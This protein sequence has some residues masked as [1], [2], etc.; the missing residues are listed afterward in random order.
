MSTL[1]NRRF[2]TRKCVVLILVCALAMPAYAQ[3]DASPLPQAASIA[4]VTFLARTRVRV[5][6][7]WQWRELESLNPVFLERSD[8]SALLLVDDAQLERLA[9]MRFSP[10]RTDALTSLAAADAA[11][12][13]RLQPLLVQEASAARL[14]AAAIRA[15]TEAN[16]ADIVLASARQSL[17]AAMQTLTA[18]QMSVL[19]TATS[20]DGDLDGLTNTQESWWCTNPANP[21]SNPISSLNDGRK[22]QQARDWVGNL[23]AGRPEAAPFAGWPMLPANLN[24]QDVDQDGV[25]DFAEKF[26]LGLNPLKEST[27]G[28]KFD[29]GQKL[30]G[31]T[32]SNWG[33]LPRSEDLA[34]IGYS[35]PSWVKAPGNHPLVAAYPLPQ[36]DIVP[37]SFVVKAV[38]TIQTERTVSENEERTY[39][40]A[41][42]EGTSTSVADTVTWNEWEEVSRS[43]QQPLQFRSFS[44]DSFDST[45]IDGWKLAGGALKVAAG[46]GAIAATCGGGAFGTLVSLGLA[47]GPA[48]LAC[49]AGISAGVP[50]AIDGFGAIG[51]G[52]KPDQVQQQVQPNNISVV[53]QQQLQLTNQ[54]DVV[55]NQTFDTSQVVNAIQGTQYTYAQTGQLVAKRL[56]GIEQ[57]VLAPRVTDTSSRGKSWGGAKTTTHEQYEQ[58]TVTNGQAFGTTQ[59]WSNA[60]AI[61]SG[62]AADF[63]FSYRIS[64]GGTDYLTSLCNLAFNIYIGDDPNPAST[65]F[66]ANDIGGDGCFRNLEPGASRT[67]SARTQT[68]AIPLSLDELRQID[69]GAPVR[70]VVADYS[71]GSDQN[72]YSNARNANVLVAIEDGTDDGDENIDTYLIPTWGEGDTMQN[73]IGRYFPSQQ[74]AQGNYVAIWTPEMRSDTPAWCISPRRYSPTSNQLWC[75]HALST[76]DWWN[77]YLNNLGDGTG[78]LNQTLAAPNSTAFFRFNKDT[79]LDGYSDRTERKLGTDPTDAA[80][81]PKPELIAGIH[82]Q[83]AVG[84]VVTATASLL[85]TGFYDAYGVELVMVAPDDSITILNNTVGGSGRVRAQRSVI[86]GS[87]IKLPDPLPGQWGQTNHAKPT[88]GGYYTGNSD[89]TYSFTASCANPGGCDVGSGALTLNWSDGLGGSGALNFGS[90]YASPTPINV[91]A[92]G[93]QLSLSSG[94]V[95]NGDTFTIAARAPQDTFSYR[96][97]RTPYTE[98]LV[99]VSYNDP[100]GN[101]RIAVPPA[102]M[103]LTAPTDNLRQFS[104]DMLPDPGV[105]LVTSAPFAPGMNTVNL[106]VHN[107]SDKTLVNAN[108]FLEFINISGTVVLEVPVMTTLPPGPKANLVSFDT[109]SFNPPYNAAEDYVVMA[110]LTDYQGNILDTAG[111]PLSSFQADPLPSLAA[112]DAALTWNFGAVKQGTLLKR[113]LALANTGF[114][115]LY[116]YVP[117]ASGLSLSKVGAGV[118]SAA[119]VSNYELTL[120]TSDVPLGPYDQT[121]TIATSDPTQPA[122]SLR[123]FGT[124]VAGAPDSAGGLARPLDVSASF[125]AGLLGT[126]QTF[127]HTLGPDPASLHPVKV[128]NSAYASPP[129]GVGRYATDFGAGTSSA[130]MFGDGRD[131]P[132]P[133]G[134]NLD[135]GTGLAWGIVNSGSAGSTSIAVADAANVSRINPGDVVLIHQTQGAGAGQWELNKS[136]TYWNGSGFTLQKPLQYTYS[137]TGSNRAQIMRVPQYST[138]DNL[139][140]G[141]VLRYH[142]NGSFGGIFIA[143]CNSAMNLNSAIQVNGSAGSTATSGNPPG[144]VGGGF[145]G[146]QGDAVNSDNHGCGYQGEG[147]AGFGWY[148]PEPNGNGGGA[149][150]GSPSTG[151]GGSGGGGGHATAGNNSTSGGIGSGGLAAGNAELTSM[152]FGG[153]GGGSNENPGYSIGGGGSGGGIV[154]LIAPTITINANG[155]ISANGGNGGGSYRGAG[156]GAGGS[157][158]L[159]ALNVNVNTN[160]ITAW[161]GQPGPGGGTGS[162]GRIRIEYCETGSGITSPN[163]SFQRINCYIADQV[164][165]NPQ[166]GQLNVPSNTAQTYQ[167]QYGRRLNFG[168]AGNQLTALRM[169]PGLLSSVT[170]Q[171]LVS[172]LSSNTAFSL[173]VGDDG[174]TDWSG[175]VGNVSTNTS[176]DLSAAFNAYWAANGASSVNPLDVPVRVSLGGAGQVLLT[177]LQTQSASSSLR[178]V[179]LNAR[180]YTRFLLDFTAGSTGSVLASLDIGDDGSVDWSAAAPVA[181][182]ARWTTGDLKNALNSYLSGRSGEVEVPIRFYVT[183]SGSA[184][185]NDYTASYASPVDLTPTSI[186]VNPPVGLAQVNAADANASVNDTRTVQA[187]LQNNG[188]A[189]S[190]PFTAAFFAYAEGWGDWYVGSVFVPNLPAGGSTSVSVPWNTSGFGGVVPVKV[191]VNPYGRVGETSMSNNSRSTTATVN[192]AKVDQT[193][194]FNDIPAKYYTE[195]PFTINAT[196]SSGLPVTFSSQTPG[197]C[198]V[199]S[200]APA[201]VT[202]IMTGTCTIRATQ[203]GDAFYNAVTLDRSFTVND[204]SKLDQTITF[205]ALPNRTFGDAPFTVTASA[206]SGLPVTIASQTPTVCTIEGNT[207]TLLS[208]GTCTLRATCLGDATYNEAPFVERSFVVLKASQTISFGALA[209]KVVGDAP[210]AVSASA[211]SGLPV[212]LRSLTPGVCNLSGNMVTLVGAGTCSI[213]ASQ[214]G[215]GNYLA[216]TP[217]MQ[218]FTVTDSPVTPT[219]PAPAPTP[220][221]TGKFVYLPLVRR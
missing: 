134:G 13:A 202:L 90:G 106:L 77:I 122:R 147:T 152:V 209:N 43:I 128:F 189:D 111:R 58:H 214:P 109:R 137:S 176:P 89:R 8:D 188:S 113:P 183:P 215:D 217:V 168:G 84:N 166:Q 80:S 95:Y 200:A 60:T 204:P 140:S 20:A 161:A 30:W 172:G 10:E 146:G 78:Q 151:N 220:P 103:R 46:V 83:P 71:F 38:T 4:S 88:A 184:K 81:Y 105:E 120:R 141:Y 33:G 5:Q 145:R 99:I 150:C 51:E 11:L 53:Q 210:F 163:A 123:V 159:R 156:G 57:A 136:A 7:P 42:T 195:P 66:V 70:V 85:N 144:G 153:G 124:I 192:A 171:A 187:T 119:D 198:T 31:I 47:A 54:V 131:G 101:H 64:N 121:I 130:D 127:N 45:D 160:K 48:G 186:A 221:P 65:Y 86:V 218:S 155:S 82:Q 56:Y 41:K 26:E 12:A 67:F 23:R 22:V 94:K 165:G 132:M 196:A 1:M 49:L 126:W 190:G 69:L 143:M 19:A 79:D 72:F 110:F 206:S 203:A 75:K 179:R 178:Y 25:P 40:T 3:P 76:A 63:W 36:I 50:T 157:V 17:R 191:V 208:T 21:N 162:D 118:V 96:I 2:S 35:M 6:T 133:T 102:A 59:G 173:D 181:A 205:A 175:T 185:I 87:S 74:D 193:I 62:H 169:P 68:R 104:G 180:T 194:A 164:A 44:T 115:Q 219:P 108:L 117:P 182:P 138:C 39:S 97:N 61:N 29:D 154:V 14:A 199:T 91:G 148:A 167:I 100:Q 55:L 27:S 213:E 93:V 129:F 92:F 9:R 135:H 201:T 16:G 158:L 116:T 15:N 114:G 18:D 139:N 197:V 125:G 32:P 177:N 142:W 107:P 207:V 73:V 52:L 37:S 216:A 170:L 174:T 212:V 98:P 211:S 24:C 149:G 112:D 34:F 28:D